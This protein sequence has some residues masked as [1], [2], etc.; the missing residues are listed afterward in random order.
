[1]TLNSVNRDTV[2]KLTF[3]FP[4]LNICCWVLATHRHVLILPFVYLLNKNEN[5]VC[6]LFMLILADKQYFYLMLVG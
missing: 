1:M 2:S 3:R 5:F 6:L 4:D